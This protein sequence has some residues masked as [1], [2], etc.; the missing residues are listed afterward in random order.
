MTN[1]GLL[2]TLEEFLSES[3]GA[4]VIEDGAMLF[5]LAEAKYS[6]SGQHNKCLLH[7][8]SQERN[9]VRRVLD[10]ESK[11]ETH[12]GLWCSGWARRVRQSLTSAGSAIVGRRQQSGPRDPR[13]CAR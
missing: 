13:I 1:E 8:W 7:L 10:V 6:I 9:I 11:G 5:D 3:S 2:R 4:V 12:C